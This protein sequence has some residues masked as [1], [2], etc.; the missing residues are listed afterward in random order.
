LTNLHG[1]TVTTV[2]LPSSGNATGIDTWSN[3]DEYGNAQTG[4]RT[5]TTGARYGWLGAKE[6][7]N[8]I[9]GLLLMGARLYNPMTGQFTSTDPIYGGNTSAFAYPQDPINRF[10]LD[11]RFSRGTWNHIAQ[12]LGTASTVAGF[13]FFC[14]PCETMSLILG[15]A[16]VVALAKAH[17]YS[18]AARAAVGLIYGGALGAIAKSL[19]KASKVL[20]KPIY[21]V[22]GPRAGRDIYHSIHYWLKGGAIFTWLAQYFPSVATALAHRRH[23]D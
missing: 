20:R 5:V 15:T 16:R 3:S 13:A 11:G 8:D 6:R 21:A 9:A 4:A 1:D 10:D 2:T 22:V 23:N 17:R 18:E 12:A 19:W 14:G 7:A